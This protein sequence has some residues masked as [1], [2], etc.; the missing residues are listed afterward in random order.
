[1]RCFRL[2]VSRRQAQGFNG[3]LGW[4]RA[5]ARIV[6]RSHLDCR[7]PVRW[8]LKVGSALQCGARCRRATVSPLRIHGQAPPSRVSPCTRTLKQDRHCSVGTG[9]R[10]FTCPDNAGPTPT[11]T[12]PRSHDCPAVTLRNPLV[13]LRHVRA[14]PLV[15]QAAKQIQGLPES[16]KGTRRVPGR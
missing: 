5:L 7:K 2:Q 14:T 8:T 10:S 16:L 6:E 3:L 15:A 4:K 11:W 9:C 1:M 12:D 13:R